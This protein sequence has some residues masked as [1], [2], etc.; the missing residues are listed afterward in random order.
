[1][2]M[3]ATALAAGFLDLQQNFPTD[4]ADGI[5]RLAGTFI[6]Y[7]KDAEAN[8]TIPIIGTAVDG[9]LGPV[10]TALAGLQTTGPVAIQAAHIA[11][12]T[13]V[14]VAPT[15]FFA[16]CS[17]PAVISPSLSTMGA[18]VLAAGVANVAADPPKTP[19]QATQLLADAIH[20]ATVTTPTT[21]TLL[22]GP[23]VVT[24]S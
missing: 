13:A 16:G 10:K 20:N 4:E 11:F 6:E 8:E 24:I 17:V 18:L 21:I 5:D 3:S 15:A 9:M 1:M 7:W 23:T 14:V 22:S 2:G 12:W 19:T